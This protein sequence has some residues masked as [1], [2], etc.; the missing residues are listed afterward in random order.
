MSPE[1]ALAAATAC[2]A[3]HP[4]IACDAAALAAH[5]RQHA[6]EA[7]AADLNTRDLHLA[8]AA[9]NGDLAAIRS[10]ERDV[11]SAARG[12]LAALRVDDSAID[13][14]VQRTREKLLGGDGAPRLLDY[15]GSGTL[16]AW[17][18]VVAIREHLMVA[19]IQRREVPLGDAILAA[20]P[21]PADDPAML[22]LR[23]RYRA[24]LAAALTTAI[25]Q[26]TAR[27]RTLLRYSLVDGLD[28]SEIGAIY[29]THKSTISRWLALAR[30]NLWRATRDALAGAFGGEEL[31]SLIRAV[32]SGLD[33]SLERLLAST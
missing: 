4:E 21:D 3:A 23:H 7:T 24:D 11:L 17:V 22:V 28:L 18:R 13:E 30:T 27:E 12:A 20:V 31:E 8:F 6:G 19:R 16:R 9:A 1:E 26:L 25:A 33:L 15:R 32:R 14:I 5:L 10:F 2:V 29:H